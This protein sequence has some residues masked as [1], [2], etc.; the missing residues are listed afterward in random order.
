MVA[1]GGASV[2]Y[3]DTISDYGF[4]KVSDSDFYNLTRLVATTVQKP[5]SY[6]GGRETDILSWRFRGV[7]VS[8]VLPLYRS[9]LTTANIL[10][11]HLSR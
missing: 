4:G 11:H 6:L 9:W 7:S 2:V 10:E 5:L 8:A 1:G 3:A